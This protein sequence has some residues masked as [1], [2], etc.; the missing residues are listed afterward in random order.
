MKAYYKIFL[1]PFLVLL[2]AEFALA[3]R[4]ETLEAKPALLTSPTQGYPGFFDTNMAEPGALIVE[5]P[6][7]ILPIIPVPS[8]AV[9]YGVNERLTVGTNALLSFLPWIAGVKSATVKARTLLY[10]TESM[11][12]TATAYLGYFGGSMNMYWQLLTSNN[13]WKLSPDNIVSANAAF[14]NFG[15]ESGDLKGTDYT[16]IQLTTGAIGGG[17]QYL[18]DETISISTYVM[19]P[20]WTSVNM[21]TSAAAFD[22]N[23]DASRGNLMWGL[24]RMSVDYRSEPWVYSLGAMYNTG[25]ANEL[26]PNSTGILPWFS[27]TRR[28]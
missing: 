6:P 10:G 9:D 17:H 19:L 8:I 23:G 13:A 1:I 27:A 12:S 28:Y 22:L 18:W 14:I 2:N 26:L 7:I 16:S 20:I 21:D 5:W 25:S 11:Q 15:L 4:G 3:Q 24:A